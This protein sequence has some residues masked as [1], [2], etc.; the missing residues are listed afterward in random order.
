MLWYG[1]RGVG[2]GGGCRAT[3]LGPGEVAHA[4]KK[5]PHCISI[6]ALHGC[7]VVLTLVSGPQYVSDNNA[8]TTVQ[9]L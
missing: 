6:T 5:R 2:V 8:S 9:I 7:K 3:S 1:F 4:H